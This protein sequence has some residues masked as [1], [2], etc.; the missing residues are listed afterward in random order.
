MHLHS[1]DLDLVPVT[2]VHQIAFHLFLQNF[3]RRIFGLLN[4]IGPQSHVHIVSPGSLDYG[5]SF[6]AD[7][8]NQSKPFMHLGFLP[9]ALDAHSCRNLARI[10]HLATH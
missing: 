7:L 9:P 8:H 1:I 2:L 6:S 5:C 3:S 10:E 4:E